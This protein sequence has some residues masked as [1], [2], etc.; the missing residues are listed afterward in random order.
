MSEYELLSP[1]KHSAHHYTDSPSIVGQYVKFNFLGNE[2]GHA[3][4]LA[5]VESILSENFR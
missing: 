4:A 3:V 5:L 2:A 1:T